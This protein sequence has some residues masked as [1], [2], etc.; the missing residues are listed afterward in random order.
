L[1]SQETGDSRYLKAA[2]RAGDFVWLAGQSS[3]QFVGGTIDSPNVL[4]KEAGTLSTEAYLA[5]FD[6]TKESQWLARAR[7][8]ADYA[9]TYI[10]IWN[11]PMPADED[12][13]LLHWKKG[14][15]TYGVQL[16]ATGHALVDD[17]MSFDVD[18]YARLARWTGDQH[19]R[20]IATSTS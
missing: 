7:V 11:V 8:A 2:E 4:D 13:T 12:D 3:G 9:E 19:Y 20:A 5:L 18:Q 17:Y 16:L 1:L 6:V 14:V 15:P 10:Y